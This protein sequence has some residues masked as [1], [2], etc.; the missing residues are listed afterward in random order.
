MNKVGILQG[1]LSPSHESKFQF[2][3]RE[4]EPEFTIARDLGLDSIEWLFDWPEYED[5]SMWTDQGRKK[6]QHISF[7]SGVAVN[8][9][10]ADYFM[11]YRLHGPDALTSIS[12]AR[13]LIEATAGTYNKLLLIPFLEHN[14][15][16]EGTEKDEVIQNLR[17]LLP[18]AEKLNVRLGFET[19]MTVTELHDFFK[20]LDSENVGAYY[21]IGNCTSYG[22]D[23]PADLRALGKRVFGIHLKDRKRG[24]TQSVTLGI[25][26]AK[27]TKCFQ[28]LKDIEYSGALIMQA[29]RGEDYL[30]DAKIQLAFVKSLL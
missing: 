24:T 12:V 1:R 19:E 15:L 13:K 3:P 14:A 17:S 28:A 20:R 6:I 26:D 25:G 5:N 2:Y 27:F 16:K 9:I 18:L 8:S 23:C 7:A 29:W 11:K 10:C 21:D 4:W 22:F 30:Q